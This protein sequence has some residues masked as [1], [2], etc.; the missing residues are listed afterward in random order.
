MSKPVAVTAGATVRLAVA[1]SVTRPDA[2]TCGETEIEE[3]S[4]IVP[5]RVTDWVVET[6]SEVSLVSVTSPLAVGVRV[7]VVAA[8]RAEVT[9]PDA[10][11]AGATVSDVVTG[12]LL[13]P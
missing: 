10:V 4:G 6:V 5:V 7:T 3:V 8:V 1:E 2:L 11:T 9:I 12:L 13:V